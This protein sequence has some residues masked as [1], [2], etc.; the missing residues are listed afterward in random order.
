MEEMKPGWFWHRLWRWGGVSVTAAARV[1]HVNLDSM[2]QH[3]WSRHWVRF[4]VGLWVVDIK[5]RLGP[6]RAGVGVS[7]DSRHLDANAELTLTWSDR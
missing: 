1:L 3:W 5:L 4:Q 7:A 2:G 6:I